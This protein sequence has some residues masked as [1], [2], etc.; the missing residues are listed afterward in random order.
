MQETGPEP[1]LSSEQPVPDE[2]R[3]RSRFPILTQIM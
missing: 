3:R 2:E 1:G